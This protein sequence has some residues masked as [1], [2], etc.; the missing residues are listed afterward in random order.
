MSRVQSVERAFAVLGALADGPLGVT[1]I[2]DRVSLPKSTVARLLRTLQEEDAVE[3]STG[4]SRYRLGERIASLAAGVT[5][6]GSIVSIARPDLEELA[7]MAGEAAGLAI[8]DGFRVHYI[9][10]VDTPNAVQARD[11][12]GT[13][14]PMHAVPSGQVILAHLPPAELERFLAEPLEPFTSRTLT[15]PPALR[16]RLDEVRLEGLA[17]VHEEFDLGIDSVAAPI[18]DSR[19]SAVA[20]IHVH[21]PS[22]RFPHR[23]SSRLAEQIVAAAAAISDRL[24]RTS[25]GVRR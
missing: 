25:G 12:T 7:S 2:A 21:G 5:V 4:D 13:R 17:W 24:D 16:R 9:D 20:A 6:G 22:Y 18:L 10:Q 19:G 14:V 8:P 11:W 3:Q 1:E 23:D 15:D